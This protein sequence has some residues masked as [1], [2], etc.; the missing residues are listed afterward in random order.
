[1][2][3]ALV[4]SPPSVDRG[5]AVHV[6]LLCEQLVSRG[7]SVHLVC[8]RT[9]FAETMAKQP[10]IPC[11]IEGDQHKK[12]LFDAVS[13]I[14]KMRSFFR[15]YRIDIVHCHHRWLATLSL[16]AVQGLHIA[17]VWTD[18]SELIGKR[19]L[20]KLMGDRVISVSKRMYESAAYVKKFR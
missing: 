15:Q 6:K 7:H 5:V 13:D 20:T 14:I 12:G 3:I 10:I 8:K 11:W 9:P 2:R 17:R 4:T 1:M 18:H 16:V 19:W